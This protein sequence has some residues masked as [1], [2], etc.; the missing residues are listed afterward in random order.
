MPFGGRSVHLSLC[1]SVC[2]CLC[3]CPSVLMSS[4]V[5]VFLCVCMSYY[6]YYVCWYMCLCVSMSVCL[7]VCLYICEWISEWMC[8]VC[9]YDNLF[10]SLG[11]S[12]YLCLYVY[13]CV[14]DGTCV[15]FSV[16]LSTSVCDSERERKREIDKQTEGMTRRARERERV[17]QTRGNDGYG[18]MATLASFKQTTS[19]TWRMC[20]EQK[21][22]AILAWGTPWVCPEYRP[23]KKY[24][25]CE[26]L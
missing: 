11:F 23:K 25:L 9:L 13:L 14:Y 26:S 7:F 18:Y 21:K 2:L 1:L 19:V 10:I 20:P 24:F 5:C 15:C 6:S 4:S 17:G 22:P 8:R 12:P 3:I 16:F